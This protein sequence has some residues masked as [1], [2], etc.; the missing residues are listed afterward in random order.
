[1]KAPRGSAVS[2]HDGRD[3]ADSI[4][5]FAAKHAISRAQTYLEIAA[6]RLIARKVGSRTIVT[7]EDAA[8]WRR[9]L[10]KMSARGAEA[11]NADDR[12]P[13]DGLPARKLSPPTPEPERLRPEL[14]SRRP[15]RPRKM[16]AAGSTPAPPQSSISTATM[17]GHQKLGPR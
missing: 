9:A 10:P 11:K 8:A 15:G 1:M 2:S 4:E 12:G 7:R 5:R 13:S 3:G 14:T 6:G 17:E 16:L